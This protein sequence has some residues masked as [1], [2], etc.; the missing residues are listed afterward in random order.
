MSDQPSN[1]YLD[2]IRGGA[3]F[4]DLGFHGPPSSAGRGPRGF[5]KGRSLV[6]E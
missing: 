4:N 5:D 3:R 2:S 6:V 1:F